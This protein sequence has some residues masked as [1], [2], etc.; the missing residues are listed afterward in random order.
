MG[1]DDGH[2]VNP[3]RRALETLPTSRSSS[4][5]KLLL[6]ICERFYVRDRQGELR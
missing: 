2:K 6:G 4:F 3:G 1:R 5:G